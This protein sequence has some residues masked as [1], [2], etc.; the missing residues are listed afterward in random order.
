[1]SIVDRINEKLKAASPDVAAEVLAFLEAL[2]ARRA[3]TAKA[4]TNA[5]SWDAVMGVMRSSKTFKD[6]PVATQ[7]ALRDEWGR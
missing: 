5:Q 3:L 2:E 6:D 4:V 7:R 1:M